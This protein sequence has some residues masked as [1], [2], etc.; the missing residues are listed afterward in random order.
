MLT[1]TPLDLTPFG[2]VLQGIGLL[3]WLILI[4]V[5]IVVIIKVKGKIAKLLSII[6]VLAIMLG[7]L[8]LQGIAQVQAKARYDAAMT[9]FQMHCK[10][11][12]EKIA[13]TVENVDGV[14]L[15]KLRVNKNDLEP[16][17][18]KLND[19]YGRDYDDEGLIESFFWGRNKN[20]RLDQGS[21]TGEGYRYVD[22]VDPKDGQRYRYTGYHVDPYH[23]K[24]NKTAPT[25]PEPRYGV[26]YDDISTREDR[27]FWIAGSSLRVIDLQTNEVIGERIGYMIDKGQG[28]QAGF[29][30]PWEFAAY[31]ACPAFPLISPD[32]PHVDQSGQTRHFVEKILKPT[33]QSGK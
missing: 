33:Q 8:V 30:Q 2:I 5:L 26:T 21:L 3:Y 14:F 16:E 23:F 29:R 19:P 13:R 32:Q 27:E 6:V 18:F 7:P 20:G 1:G 12:G 31:N 28:S 17:Q 22:A 25:T 9:R 24:L 4:V 15:M 10:N 11:A